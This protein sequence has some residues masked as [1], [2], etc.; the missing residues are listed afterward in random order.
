MGFREEIQIYIWMRILCNETT[1]L[2]CS[3]DLS[4]DADNKTVTSPTDLWQG[5]QL[6]P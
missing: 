6:L 4:A 1:R 5:S 2:K 3:A